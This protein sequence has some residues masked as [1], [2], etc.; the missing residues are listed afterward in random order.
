MFDCQR[1][2]LCQGASPV[3]LEQCPVDRATAST[4]FPQPWRGCDRWW[5][6]WSE[7]GDK[8]AT[9]AL[10]K[11]QRYFLKYADLMGD[12]NHQHILKS[13]PLI[14]RFWCRTT[15]CLNLGKRIENR[16]EVLRIIHSKKMSREMV[17]KSWGPVRAVQ[18][19]CGTSGIR[20]RRLVRDQLHEAA[21][22]YDNSYIYII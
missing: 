22:S 15:W 20:W 6:M 17:P 18:K 2:V 19:S 13:K 8:S 21:H 1:V 3:S 10:T 5:Q 14:H 16:S 11:R 7:R 12:K 9:Q 4:A